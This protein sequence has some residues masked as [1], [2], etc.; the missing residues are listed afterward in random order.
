VAALGLAAG[1]LPGTG[2]R[3]HRGDR[4][5]DR[6]VLGELEALAVVH[7]LKRRAAVGQCVGR[8]VLADVDAKAGAAIDQVEAKPAQ[9]TGQPGRERQPAGVVSRPAEAAD[10]SGPRTR[11]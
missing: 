4:Q 6:L 8:V 5:G 3:R 2:L 1:G 7:E 9:P 11:E 10:E